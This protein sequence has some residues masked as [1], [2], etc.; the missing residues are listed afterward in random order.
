MTVLRT[1]KVVLASASPRRVRLLEQL[2][3]A[4]ESA[5]VGIDETRAP[6]EAPE[7]YVVRLARCKAREAVRLRG[8]GLP[9]LA[10]DTAVVLDGEVFG[11]PAGRAGAAK[12]LA[13]LSGRTHRVLTGVALLNGGEEDVCLDCSDVKFAEIGAECIETYLDTGEYRDKAGA[14]AIQGR[15]AAFIE[16][17]EGSYSGVMGLPLFV[18]SRMLER[19]GLTERA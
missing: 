10:A 4:Y 14:Y 17:L 3:V 2:G 6:S 11:K 5:P 13:A 9:V 16:R 1:P 7:D 18:V 19:G 8:T 12:M 15:A